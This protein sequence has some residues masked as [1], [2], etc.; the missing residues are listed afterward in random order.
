MRKRYMNS[1]PIVKI[2][3]VLVSLLSYNLSCREFGSPEVNDGLSGTILTPNSLDE[4]NSLIQTGN[5][6]VDFHGEKWCGP[7]KMFAP[8]FA[9][10]AASTP[11]VIFVKV[12]VDKL[13]TDDIRGVPTIIFYKDG[14][15]MF[16]K[17]GSMTESQ[18]RALIASTFG[19]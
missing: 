2:A 7:C 13:R 16:R 4:L 12:D 9:K 8:I 15:Q 10:V 5:V 1:S 11:N 19:A 6:V 17:T 18:F 14:N 3:V